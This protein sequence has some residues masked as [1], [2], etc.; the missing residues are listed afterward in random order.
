MLCGSQN[1][2]MECTC[3]DRSIDYL[4][5]KEFLRALLRQQPPPQQIPACIVTSP[6]PVG[7]AKTKHG[8]AEA[9]PNREMTE[10]TQKCRRSD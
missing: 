10:M 6:P 5:L 9:R 8:I 4:I 7:A 2:T 1:L 3:R